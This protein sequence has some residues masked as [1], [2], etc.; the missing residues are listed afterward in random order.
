MSNPEFNPMFMVIFS[1]RVISHPSALN[2]LANKSSQLLSEN[3]R[4]T[5]VTMQSRKRNSETR[6]TI[7]NTNVKNRTT[8]ESVK[9]NSTRHIGGSHE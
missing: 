4:S 6:V 5:I 1:D 8:T 2:V 3:S 7:N 9:T